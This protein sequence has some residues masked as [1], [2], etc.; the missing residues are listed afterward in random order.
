[1]ESFFKRMII[2]AAIGLT[3]FVAAQQA[4]ATTQGLPARSQ[5]P[6]SNTARGELTRVDTTDHLLFLKTAAED[7][8]FQY[9][10]HTKVIGS[11]RGS[12]G[13]PKLTGSHVTI[14]YRTEGQ[15]DLAISVEVKTP[16]P[17]PSVPATR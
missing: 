3:A 11:E 6:I 1:M 15:I 5:A 4:I 17:P 13:L 16:Q 10:D 14:E 8:E 9:D 12:A 7:M 2:G